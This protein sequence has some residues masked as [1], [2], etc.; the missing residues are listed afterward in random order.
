MITQVVDFI[1]GGLF[2]F[3]TSLFGLLPESPLPDLAAYVS[4][5]AIGTGLGW[6][7]WFIPVGTL[8]GI[9]TAWVACLA[10][11]AAFSIVRKWI[12]DIKK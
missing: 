4:G 10:F 5:S 11:Y 7:N 1:L 2:T 6:L 12:E 9:A 3:L 8:F